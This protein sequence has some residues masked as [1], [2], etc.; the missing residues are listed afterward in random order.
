MLSQVILIAIYAL[1]IGVNMAL[2]GEPKT[3][4]HSV[5]GSLI[6]TALVFSILYTGGFWDVFL[7]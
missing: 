3:G 7:K 4:R 2:H 6:G 1:S 5:W